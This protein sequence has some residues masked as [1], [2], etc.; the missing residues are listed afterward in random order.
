MGVIFCLVSRDLSLLH[1]FQQVL[2]PISSP[3]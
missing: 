2:R 3:I 1:S